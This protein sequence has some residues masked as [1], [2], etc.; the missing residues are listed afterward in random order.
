MDYQDGNALAGPLSEIFTL[1]VTAAQGT[2]AACG[3]RARWP[4]CTSTAPAP[5]W[6]PAVPGARRSC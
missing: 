6:W 5:A 3:L 4:G 1:D 2:C